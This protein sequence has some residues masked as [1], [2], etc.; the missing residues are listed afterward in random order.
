M[1]NENKQ[2]K[3]PWRIIVGI[4]AIVYIIFMWI[5]K[6]MVS[7]Y[8]TMPQEEVV[9]LI[10]T[11]LAVSLIKVSVIAGGILLMK[12]GMKRQGGKDE[13]VGRN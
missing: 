3:E 6:D 4:I 9:P 10:V 13:C 7:I 8:T 5:K 11:T 1:N 2:K 12:W